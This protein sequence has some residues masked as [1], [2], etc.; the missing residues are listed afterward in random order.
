MSTDQSE[1]PPY[2]Y[3]TGRFSRNC[4]RP[5]DA[6]QEKA[7]GGHLLESREDTLVLRRSRRRFGS[8]L[9]TISSVAKTLLSKRG[10]ACL[11]HCPECTNGGSLHSD[12]HLDGFVLPPHI[13]FGHLT[14][15]RPHGHAGRS[16]SSPH[17]QCWHP[18]STRLPDHHLRGDGGVEQNLFPSHAAHPKRRP[19]APQ[20]VRPTL[21]RIVGVPLHVFTTLLPLQMRVSAR[22]ASDAS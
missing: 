6:F 5:P 16:S 4:P 8:G 7:L 2:M 11:N 20:S 9:G 10:V 1:I 18:G 15:K 17:A 14:T 3:T 21:I 19:D 13:P 22:T 12:R